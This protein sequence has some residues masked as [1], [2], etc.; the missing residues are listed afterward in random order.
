M[1][2]E[3]MTG[4]IGGPVRRR[5]VP[6]PLMMASV[7]AIALGLVPTA[8]AEGDAGVHAFFQDQVQAMTATAAARRPESRAIE[9]A[10]LTIRRAKARQPVYASSRAEPWRIVRRAVA[11]AP[12]V[13]SAAPLTIRPSAKPEPGVPARSISI[14]EDRTLRRGD[15]VILAQGPRVFA[16]SQRFP[17]ADQDFVAVGRVAG[18]SKDF[19]RDLEAIANNPNQRI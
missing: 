7:L 11:A 10:P 6:R 16:G 19:Q 8:R 4:A 3:V 2:S 18:V 15:V 14:F 9:A 5:G 1:Q 17:Y 12:R 13:A